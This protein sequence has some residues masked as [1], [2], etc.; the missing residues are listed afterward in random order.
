VFGSCD[1]GPRS[2]HERR[3]L[4][5]QIAVIRISKSTE[6]FRP[7][8]VRLAKVSDVG[9]RPE[10]RNLNWLD[11]TSNKAKRRWHPLLSVAC[12]VVLDCASDSYA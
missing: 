12:S 1:D 7:G 6:R 9:M 2:E 5:Y 10:W 4:G 8:G 11:R 3:A